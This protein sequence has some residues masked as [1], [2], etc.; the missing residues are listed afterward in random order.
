MSML[1]SIPGPFIWC[2][3]CLRELL[4]WLAVGMSF[5]ADSDFLVALETLRHLRTGSTETSLLCGLGL[6]PC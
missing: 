2:F 1:R 6:E 5:F 3:S 4:A